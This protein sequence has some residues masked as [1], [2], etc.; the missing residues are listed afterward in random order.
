MR[1]LY[2]LKRCNRKKRNNTGCIFNK[3]LK[4]LMNKGGIRILIKIK[5][6]VFLFKMR[7]KKW[8]DKN[9]IKYLSAML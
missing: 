9:L 8:I 4:K 1:I 5:I 2:W 6:M 3:K 7:E